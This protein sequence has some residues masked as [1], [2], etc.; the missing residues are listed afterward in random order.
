MLGSFADRPSKEELTNV[1]AAPFLSPP[2]TRIVSEIDAEIDED[3]L[4]NSLVVV[5]N[6]GVASVTKSELLICSALKLLGLG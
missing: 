3:I 6:A 2:A 1:C 5:S 4:G